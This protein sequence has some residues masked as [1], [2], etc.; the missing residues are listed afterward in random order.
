MSEFSSGNEAVVV[1]VEDLESLADLLLG[2][3]VLHLA[4]HHGKE[5][6]SPMEVD[7]AVVVSVDLVDHVLK[8]RLG[9]VLAERAHDGSE[10]LGGDLTCGEFLAHV[11]SNTLNPKMRMRLRVVIQHFVG[12][13]LTIAF[14]QRGYVA[15]G[16]A[17]LTIA[18]L[19][20]HSEIS[21]DFN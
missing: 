17:S 10:L 18:I 21:N 8:L 4:R 9:G 15:K 2:V 19:V 11:L 3:G 13:N 6:F 14:G 16:A 1:T 20:L 7:G 5:L 12:M